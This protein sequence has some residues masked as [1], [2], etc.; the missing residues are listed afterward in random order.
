MSAPLAGEVVCLHCDHVDYVTSGI[1][2][3]PTQEIV[4]SVCAREACTGCGSVG[5][6]RPASS[7]SRNLEDDDAA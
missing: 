2:V 7:T 5:T 3:A 6:L 4:E 1:G